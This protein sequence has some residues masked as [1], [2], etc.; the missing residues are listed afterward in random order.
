M[1]AMNGELVLGARFPDRVEVPIQLAETKGR[2]V[3]A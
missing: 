3:M 1:E 2:G